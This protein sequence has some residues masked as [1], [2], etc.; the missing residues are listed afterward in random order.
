V[1]LLARLSRKTKLYLA[2][3]ASVL[4]LLFMF[5]YVLLGPFISLYAIKQGVENKNTKVLARYIDFESVRGSAKKQVQKNIY[6]SWGIDLTKKDEQRDMFTSIAY[7]FADKLVDT[8]VESAVSPTGIALLLSGER[9]DFQSGKQEKLSEQ[10]SP[11]ASVQTE[12]G[13]ETV[14]EEAT[15]KEATSKVTASKIEIQKPHSQKPGFREWLKRGEYEYHSHDRFS[16]FLY[17]KNNKQTHL[18]LTRHGMRWKLSD[19]IFEE[20]MKREQP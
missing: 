3:G 20:A 17:D 2:A 1:N 8:A 13:N 12:P 16:L 7:R 4:V 19:V 18:V 15:S 14:S 10:T 6:A 9:I 5:M 11:Q